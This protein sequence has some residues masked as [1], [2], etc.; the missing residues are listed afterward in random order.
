MARCS[1][2]EALVLVAPS[3]RLP[4]YLTLRPEP[5]R[6][7]G[8]LAHA[9]A[10]H[11]ATVLPTGEVLVTGGHGGGGVLSSTEIYDPDTNT[12]TAGPTL[13]QARQ[14]HASQLL[15]NGL[16]LISGG[17]TN[18]SSNWDIQTH[19][20]SSAELYD[21]ATNT[22]T[23]TGSKTNA[24]SGG[25]PILALDWQVFARGRRHERSRALYSRDAGDAR[26][27]GSDGEY[28]HGPN[29]SLYGICSTTAE[30]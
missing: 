8:S 13:K 24:T 19:F 3:W 30:C 17:N 10:N 7:A 1:L 14:S 2:P 16:V 20:L 4:S 6:A 12:F 28:G 26:D 15:P 27:L 22:F 21:P 9:R 5:S 25:N 23:T 11:G 18:S 29:Q